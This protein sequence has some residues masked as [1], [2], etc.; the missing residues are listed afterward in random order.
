MAVSTP[1]TAGQILTSAYVNNNI[2]SGLVYIT[3]AN[4]TGSSLSINNCFTSTYRNYR[5]VVASTQ[6]AGN[7]SWNFRFRVG[8]VDNSS[9]N[10]KFAQTFVTTVGGTGVDSANAGTEVRIGY[11]ASANGDTE[12]V[13]DIFDPQATARTKGNYQFFGYDSATWAQRQ[14][15]WMFDQTTQFDGI[16]FLTG[17]SNFTATVYVYGYRQA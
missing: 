6:A 4:M 10:Y 14:A 17:G 2:N 5:I 15:G 9:A 16:T 11:I 3:Q 12:T 7:T 13:M 1:T 8:G